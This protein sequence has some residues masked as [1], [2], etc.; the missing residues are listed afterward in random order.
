VSWVIK[1]DVQIVHVYGREFLSLSSTR[2][3]VGLD[4]DWPCEPFGPVHC[5]RLAAI[6][7]FPQVTEGIINGDPAF[8]GT[9]SDVQHLIL[10][11]KFILFAMAF[12]VKIAVLHD[13][14]NCVC[15]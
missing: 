10:A 13:S 12:G 6:H 1:Q 4:I 8:S 7:L 15:H 11:Y 14:E 2:W 5:W 3:P 9:H